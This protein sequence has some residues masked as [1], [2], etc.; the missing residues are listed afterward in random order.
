[1]PTHDLAAMSLRIAASL[2]GD[3]YAAD[4]PRLAVELPAVWLSSAAD[5]ALEPILDAARGAA[6]VNA[7][8]RPEAT[9]DH[10]SQQLT[11]WLVELSDAS[12]AAHLVSLSLRPHPGH[13]LLGLADGALFVLVVAR[14]VVEGVPSYEE[15]TRLGRFA[16][17]I[18]QALAG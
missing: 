16:N 9:P 6:L 11:A 3:D 5:P 15:G 10:A 13:A 4:D 2:R 7:R 17:G 1:V 14:S 18:R 8:L 12:A